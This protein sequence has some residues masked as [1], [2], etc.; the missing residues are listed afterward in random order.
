MRRFVADLTGLLPWLMARLPDAAEPAPYGVY[1]VAG[2]LE[3]VEGV[4]VVRNWTLP[5]IGTALD[6]GHMHV[7]E[8]GRHSL[9]AL[10]GL[11]AVI[12]HLNN[13]LRHLHVHDVF[14]NGLP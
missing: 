13:V 10:G 1:I 14:G 5:R 11:G 4:D 2:G 3:I 7:L 8:A 9:G 6:V 12:R